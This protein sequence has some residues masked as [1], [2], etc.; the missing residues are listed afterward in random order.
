MI[1]HDHL[2]MVIKIIEHN[3]YKQGE[4]HLKI[5]IFEYNKSAWFDADHITVITPYS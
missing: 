5:H 2:G 1:K 3:L 4:Q